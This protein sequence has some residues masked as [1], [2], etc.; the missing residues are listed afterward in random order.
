MADKILL[1]DAC[2]HIPAVGGGKSRYMKVGLAFRDEQERISIKIDTLPIASAGWS[3][4][5]NVFPDKRQAQTTE[6]KG[7]DI[8][9]D[10]I[11]F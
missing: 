8:D 1:G 10:D 9:P 5:I 6:K 4:W 7:A 11:P 3:G 2:A